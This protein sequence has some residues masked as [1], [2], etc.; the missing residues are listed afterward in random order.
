MSST[1]VGTIGKIQPTQD[2]ASVLWVLYRHN[3]W[4]VAWP[5]VVPRFMET[6][7]KTSVITTK[8]E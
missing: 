7:G 3:S 6:R 8:V 1:P 5:T 4:H 2:A